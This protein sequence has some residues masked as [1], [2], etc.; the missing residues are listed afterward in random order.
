[1]CTQDYT[2]FITNQMR[3]DSKKMF[4]HRFRSKYSERFND[5][6]LGHIMMELYKKHT[7]EDSNHQEKLVYEM[8]FFENRTQFM[9][10]QR[11]H[12]DAAKYYGLLDDYLPLKVQKVNKKLVMEFGATCKNRTDLY[13]KKQYYYNFA[14]RHG[15]MDEIE[16]T[17]DSHARNNITIESIYEIAAKCKNKTELS[18]INQSAYKKALKLGMLDNLRFNNIESTATYIL[19]NIDTLTREDIKKELSKHIKNPEPVGEF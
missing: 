8:S 19:E 10:E 6:T 2:S 11:K 17:S 9:K 18:R 3:D 5:S 16:F 4:S 1:M 15:F 14:L 12:Y 13:N 7:G